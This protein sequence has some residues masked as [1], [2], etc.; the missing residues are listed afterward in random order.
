MPTIDSSLYLSN[1]SQTRE[2]SS[3]LGKEDF[4]KILM[5]QLQNQNPLDPMKDKEFISQMTTFSQMEQMM[6]MSESID[7][8]VK[9]QSVSPVIQ[10]SHL[11]GKEVSYYKFDEETGEII[12]PKETL[13]SKVE[14]VSQKDGYGVLELANDTDIFTDEVLKIEQDTSEQQSSTQDGSNG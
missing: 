12:E 10:N 6:N 14:A 5:T 13:T 11:I 2:P 1:Q 8:L 3:N 7:Q 4:L 9:N